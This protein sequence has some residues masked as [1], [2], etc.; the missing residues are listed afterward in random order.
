[1]GGTRRRVLRF[2]PPASR[3]TPGAPAAL[4]S[5]SP[6]VLHMYVR[7]VC[8]AHTS[9]A[10]LLGRAQVTGTVCMGCAYLT[11]DGTFTTY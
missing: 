8:R 3:Y 9:H 1:M 11:H 5:P 4:L 7:T 2:R 6:I 10:G